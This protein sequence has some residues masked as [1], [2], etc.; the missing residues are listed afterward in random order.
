M[1]Q[2]FLAKAGGIGSFERYVVLKTI[3]PD[4]ADDARFISMFLDEARLSATL[5]HQN[6]AQV[7]EVDEADGAYFMAMEY[8]HGE[9]VRSLLENTLK[10][11][12]T[13]PLELAV[14]IVSGSA[15]GLHHAHERRAKNGQS[16]NIVHRDVSPANIMVGYDGGVKVLD[17]GI[18]KAEE[19]S[20]KTA[21]GTIK[22]KY[23]Y[24]SPEQCR[25]KAV[26]RR[27][28]IFALGI[29]LYELTTLRRAFRGSD[30]F[31]T[32]RRI[33][34]GD[35]V[36][37]SV[38]VP[39]YPRDLEAIVLKALARDTEYRYQTAQDLLEALDDFM[40]KSK[41]SSSATALS[42]FMTK[43]FG[44][45]REPWVD[46]T[47]GTNPPPLGNVTPPAPA[48]G[49]A[50]EIAAAPSARPV[51]SD[52]L[53]PN[54]A[55]VPPRESRA[56]LAQQVPAQAVRPP[57]GQMP[58][59]SGV[60]GRPTPQPMVAQQPP[61]A[62]GAPTVMM[63]GPVPV[64]RPTPQPMAAQQPPMA[65]GAPTVMMSGPAPIARPTP[66]PMAAQQPP[67]GS[68]AATVMM[69]GAVPVPHQQVVPP[70][71]RPTGQI[72]TAADWANSRSNQTG[73]VPAMQAP[74]SAQMSV[75]P[76][77]VP[78]TLQRVEIPAGRKSEP[79]AAVTGSGVMPAQSSSRMP[80]MRAGTAQI[81][82]LDLQPEKKKSSMM[83]VIILVLASAI[84]GGG[85]ATMLM[86][87]GASNHAL[88]PVAPA[89]PPAH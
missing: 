30:D 25:G 56:M 32:M 82:A 28:D 11:S 49:E 26:D 1:A 88:A 75:V 41:L 40:V 13:I 33:V 63:S 81:P 46:R 15:A 29:V 16:L 58:S 2:I 86:R 24:M 84:I 21:M 44:S 59:A 80:V 78:G 48:Q 73:P 69:T 27:S 12:L 14:T 4:R 76:T 87:R 60:V 22:G 83:L 51:G 50:T 53:Q 85:A 47:G 42:R 89:A 39:G 66:Q 5:N 57:T 79:I 64:A 55:L 37:P 10:K 8:V 67:M 61:M 19:R 65:S 38:A 9:N 74:V 31:D 72:K 3:L 62:G 17:F 77:P 43:V 20:T 70:S 68:G 23:G 36:P 34:N 52:T 7:Y 71:S 6:I 18:A 45:K 54:E 35:L